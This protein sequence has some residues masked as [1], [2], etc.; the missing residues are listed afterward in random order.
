MS[1]DDEIF[2]IPGQQYFEIPFG[3]QPEPPRRRRTRRVI[4]GGTAVVTALAVAGWGISDAFASGHQAK[5]FPAV[6]TLTAESTINAAKVATAVD[7]A[8]VD[9]DATDGYSSEADAGTGMVISSS[10]YVLTNN[11]VV[12]GATAVSVTLTSTGK[13]YKA[14][15]VGTDKTADVALLKLKGASGLA[16]IPVGDATAATTGIAVAALGN[17]LGKA[18]TPTETTGHVT[19]VNKSITASDGAGSSSETLSGMLETDADIVSGDSGGPLVDSSGQVIGMDTAAESGA[20]GGFGFGQSSGTITASSDGYAIPVTTALSIARKIAGHEASSTIVIGTPG[21]L[22]L[23]LSSTA[24]SAGTS[25]GQGFGGG[26]GYGGFGSD[27]SSGGAV[28][29]AYDTTA[30][31]TVAGV[32]SGSPAATA[33]IAEGDIVTAVNGTKVTTDTALTAVMDKTH[34]GD[35]VTVAWTDTSGASHSASITLVDGPAA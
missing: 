19:G 9:I 11:H 29:T 3:P 18:G 14:T 23:E 24:G 34:G 26:Q 17:A 4:A 28:G 16:T 5:G 2:Q 31:V 20:G 35:K 15:V 12:D 7:K 1:D 33:G 27:G 21:F 10:G 32:V 13:R 8:I 6:A 25:G 30:G 22:G